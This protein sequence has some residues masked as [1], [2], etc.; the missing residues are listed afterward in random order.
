MNRYGCGAP[1]RI[2]YKWPLALDLILEAFRIIGEK[3]VLQWFVG[4]FDRVGLTFEVDAL[5]TKSI[6][7]VDPEN[8]ESILS[9]NFSGEGLGPDSLRVRGRIRIIS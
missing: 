1:L 8:L 6:D 5:G 2:K 9:T 3:Q 4:W 7:T